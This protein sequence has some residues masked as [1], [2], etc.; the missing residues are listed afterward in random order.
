MLFPD[1]STLSFETLSV[2]NRTSHYYY[3]E[4]T[5]RIRELKNRICQ[6]TELCRNDSFRTG[7]FKCAFLYRELHWSSLVLLPR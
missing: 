7:K 4:Q 5:G 1:S 2:L 6:L 3:D